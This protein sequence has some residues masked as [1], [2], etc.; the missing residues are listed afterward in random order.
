MLS[1]HDVFENTIATF[2]GIVSMVVACAVDIHQFNFLVGLAYASLT[3][4]S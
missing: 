1:S 2:V 4:S 3:R